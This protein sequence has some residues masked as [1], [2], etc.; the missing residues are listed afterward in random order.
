MASAVRKLKECVSL[1]RRNVTR[2]P[3]TVTCRWLIQRKWSWKRHS[4]NQKYDSR[5]N[6]ENS[7]PKVKRRERHRC[8]NVILIVFSTYVKIC[9]II[10]IL[11]TYLT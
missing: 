7:K 5:Q 11:S 6:S 3:M 1:F 2:Q 8:L 10:T 9:W 4:Q